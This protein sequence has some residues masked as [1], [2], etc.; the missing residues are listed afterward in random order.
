MKNKGFF[1][2]KCYVIFSFE[3]KTMITICFITLILCNQIKIV[4]EAIKFFLIKVL[5]VY[6]IKKSYR[7]R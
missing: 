2:K 3:S 7:I 4:K 5:I 6:L 1:S